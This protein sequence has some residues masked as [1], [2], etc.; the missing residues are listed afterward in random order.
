VYLYGHV[1]SDYGRPTQG[2]YQRFEDLKA[3]L[4]PHLGNLKEV[5]STEVAQFN[6]ML[7]QKGV[8]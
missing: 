4:A 6:T 1:A 7:Q 2:S 5:L 8:R 3:E